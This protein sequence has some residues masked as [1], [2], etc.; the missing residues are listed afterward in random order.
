MNKIQTKNI[1]TFQLY[2]LIAVLLALGA[3][4]LISSGMFDSG[5]L[6]ANQHN[7]EQNRMGSSAN[8]SNINEINRLEEVVK[9]NPTNYEALLQLGH[10]LN[11]S[12]F[13]ERAIEKYKT[14]LKDHPDNLDVIVDMGVCYYELKKYD[15]SLEI[16]K[17]A[18]DK[19]PQH[20]IANFNL[21]IVHFSNNNLSEAKK[22]W[23]KARDINP[24]TN[25]GQ[26]A[27]ELI[28]SNN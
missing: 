14:Y 5:V 22:W 15:Q 2:G 27:E 23:E 28:K 7:H 21:G 11:D 10:L 6:T 3:F 9:G 1:S 4:I 19:N 12:G 25:I 20:Q 8:L 13:Y 16:I 26:K 18:V 17:R 24:S